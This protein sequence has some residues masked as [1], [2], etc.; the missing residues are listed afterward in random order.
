MSYSLINVSSF[1]KITLESQY[2]TIN[3]QNDNNYAIRRLSIN[4]I[5]KGDPVVF[6]LNYI[7]ETAFDNVVK[8]QG[9]IEKVSQ[10]VST[11]PYR[12]TLIATIVLN[13]N[14][15]TSPV[16]TYIYLDKLPNGTIETIRKQCKQETLK[17]LYTYLIT[18]Q[19][20]ENEIEGKWIILNSNI[21]LSPLT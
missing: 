4:L 11:I 13:C 2:S 19:Y 1:K 3:I 5:S 7:G 9:C 8:L 15:F 14:Y 20:I 21:T 6:N 18:Y 10:N 12:L 16:E 17:I